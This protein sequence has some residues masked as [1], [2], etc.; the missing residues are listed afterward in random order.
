MDRKDHWISGQFCGQ[1]LR[2]I[3]LENKWDINTESKNKVEM[4]QWRKCIK[5]ISLEHRERKQIVNAK[6]T[7]YIWDHIQ[8]LVIK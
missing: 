1:R 4:L 3:N 7:L 5:G 6:K 8:H 2:F